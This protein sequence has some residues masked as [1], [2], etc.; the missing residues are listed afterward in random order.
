[1]LSGLIEKAERERLWL[2]CAY[3]D[4]WF[5]PAELR[6]ENAKG[7]F[8]WG[9]ENWEL[10]DPAEGLAR[11]RSRAADAKSEVER[12]EGRLGGKL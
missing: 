8:L 6:K 4:L 9:P 11:L 5:S 1:V 10:R 3:Q 2:H 12:F 7:R